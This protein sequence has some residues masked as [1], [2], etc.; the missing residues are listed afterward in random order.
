[1]GGATNPNQPSLASRAMRYMR[2]HDY[3][4]NL[5]QSEYPS[6]EEIARQGQPATPSA[7][8]IQKALKVKEADEKYRRE[9]QAS[10]Y[11][12]AGAEDAAAKK[13]EVLE[14]RE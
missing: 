7:D 5:H 8:E 12:K 4:P 3:H 1:M 6:E 10:E 14:P 11:Q 13:Q 2:E 9:H